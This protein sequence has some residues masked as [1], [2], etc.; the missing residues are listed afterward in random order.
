MK[1]EATI[2]L[3]FQSG[4]VFLIPSSVRKFTLRYKETILSL[5]SLL[6]VLNCIHLSPPELSTA[7]TSV[8][9]NRPLH[10]PQSSCSLLHVPRVHLPPPHLEKQGVHRSHNPTPSTNEKGD[11]RSTGFPHARI[12]KWAE[13]HHHGKMSVYCLCALFFLFFLQCMW[14]CSC[15]TGRQ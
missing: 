8:L 2:T 5:N 9:L 10:T 7:Y 4:R 13:R 15:C 11:R 12:S 1:Q 3:I 6:N 14:V